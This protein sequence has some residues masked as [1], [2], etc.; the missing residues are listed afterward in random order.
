VL[1][2]ASAG[3]AEVA[4]GAGYH[5]AELVGDATRVR[6]KVGML[7]SYSGWTRGAG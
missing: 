4:P 7:V 6:E 1:D 2:H 3:Q 5:A